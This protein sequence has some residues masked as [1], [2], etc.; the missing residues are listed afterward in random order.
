LKQGITAS[1]ENVAR[2]I[3]AESGPDGFDEVMSEAL[4]E[5]SR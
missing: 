5:I 1:S 4:I 2:E 3:V